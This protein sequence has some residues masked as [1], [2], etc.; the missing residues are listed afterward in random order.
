ME[1][2]EEMIEQLNAVNELEGEDLDKVFKEE[3]CVKQ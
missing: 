1:T 3:I 2:F